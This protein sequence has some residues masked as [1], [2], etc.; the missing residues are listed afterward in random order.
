[1]ALEINNKPIELKEGQELVEWAPIYD[2]IETGLQVM[3]FYEDKDKNLILTLNTYVQFIEGIDEETYHD[4]LVLP[5]LAI[6]PEA[7]RFL[8]LGGGDGLVARTIL[9]HKPEADITLV[10]LDKVMIEQFKTHARLVKINENSLGKCSIYIENAL[11]WVPRNASKI[12]DIVILDF[13]DPTSWELKRLYHKDFLADV[14]YLL[15]ESGVMSIQCNPEIADWI[16]HLTKEILGNSAVIN[17]EMPNL[18]CGKI[19]L[20]RKE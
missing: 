3:K 9:R 19:V 1:M 10:E 11:H 15:G 13:P 20:G 4:S 12:F 6:N 14:A 8:I 17:Y 5:A 18:G 16:E 2:E 7:K